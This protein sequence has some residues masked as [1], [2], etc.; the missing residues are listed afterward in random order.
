MRSFSTERMRT[1]LKQEAED[2]AHLLVSM[3]RP[4]L[5]S[6]TR[7]RLCKPDI[8]GQMWLL[9]ARLHCLPHWTSMPGIGERVWATVMLT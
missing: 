6:L 8:W 1:F 2:G 3:R 4:R 5:C 9:L 7:L